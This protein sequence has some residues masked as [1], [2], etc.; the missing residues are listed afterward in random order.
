[1]DATSS[2]Q[3]Q[4]LQAGAPLNYVD[5][6]SPMNG[7]RLQASPTDTGTGSY[8]YVPGLSG[9]AGDIKGSFWNLVLSD[10]C[11]TDSQCAVPATCVSGAC[12]LGEGGIPLYIADVEKDT[13][14]NSSKYPSNDDIYLYTV[15]YRQPATGQWS[16]LCPLDIYGK[17]DAIAIPLD[18]SDWTSAASRAKFSFACT[19]SGVAAKC[20]RNWGYK[21]WKTVT[22][23]VWNGTGFV[24]TAVDLSGFYNTCLIAARADYCQDDHSYTKNGTLVDLFDTLD[25]FTSVNSTAG[26]AFAP[27][28]STVM[29]H[30]EYQI[31]V[32]SRVSSLFTP[33]ELSNM[34]VDTQT[35]VQSLRRSG[36]ES[37]RYA[38][39]D[40]G[41]SC[42]AAPYIERCDP[43]E[44]YACYR[45]I[46][47]SS[48]P[49]GA[50]LALNS[51]RHCSHDEVTDGEALDPLCN[52]CVNRVCQVDPTCCG[53]PGSG[54][55]PGSLV[56]D[57][58]CSTIRQQVCRSSATAGAPLWPLG[59]TAPPAGSHPT[60]FLNGAIGSFEGIVSQT[61]TQFAEGWACDPDF[62]GVSI[63]IQISVGGEL[64]AAGATLFTATADQPL[65]SGWKEAVAAECGGA[66]RQG[67]HFQLPAGSTGKDVFVYGIDLNVP[68]A[69]FSLLRGGMKT[70]PAG[71]PS[72]APMAAIWTGWVQP[73]APGNYSFYAIADST[74]QYRVWVNG[75]YVAGNWVDPDPNAPGAF[76]LPPPSP[77]PSLYL[78]PGVR[79]GVRVEYLRPA[80]LPSTS[81]FALDWS[82][83]GG[84]TT[85][86]IPS[87]AFYPMAQG[88]G[89]GLLGTYFAGQL[90][91]GTQQAT[92]TTGAVDYLWTSGKPPVPG[93]TVNNPFAATFEGQVVPPISG[94]YTFTTATDGTARIF[95]N[96]QLVTAGAIRPTGF[97]AETCSHDICSTGA[98]ISRTCP[99]GFF[100][101]GLICDFDPRCCSITWDATCQQEVARI[102][103]LDCN[104]TPPLSISL[105]AGVKY[106]IRVEYQHLSG[107]ATLQ[108]MWALPGALREVIPAERLFAAPVAGASAPGVGINAAYFSDAAFNAEYLDH[109]EAGPTFDAGMP[110][111]ATL[112]PSLICTSSVCGS[113]DPPGAPVLVSAQ[114]VGVNG[115]AVSVDVQGRGA[116]QGAA[117]EIWDGTGVDQPS[118]WVATTLIDSFTIAAGAGG[119]TFT[120]SLNL[121][122]GS[123]QLA[124]KQTVSAQ[125]SVFSPALVF[126]AADPAA[127]AAPTV[128]VPMGG[129]VSG[130]GKVQ[131]GGTAVP[132]ATVNVTAGG[133]TTLATDGS[134]LTTGGTTTTFATDG[135]GN[136]SGLLTLPSVG[137][138]NVCITQSVAGI[139]SAAGVAATVIVALPP[140]T[141]T[142]PIDG[143]TVSSPLG[144]VGSG[145]DPSLGNVIVGDGDGRFFA[146]RGT[147]SVNAGG[148]FSGGAVALD[149][150][151][152]QLK[153]FQRANGLDGD[154]VLRTVLVAPPVGELTI[155]SPIAGAIV[156]ASVHVQGTSGLVRNGLPGTVIVYQGATK[157]AEAPRADDGSFDI[158]VTLTG[159]G[160]VTL[161]V[162]QTASSLSGGGSAESARTA[163]I[164]IVLHPGAPTITLPVTGAVQPGLSVAVSGNAEPNAGVEIDVDGLSNATVSAT[165]GGTFSKTLTLT[166][167]T[168][169]ITAIQ[170]LS[171]STSSAS[172]SILVTLGDV[173]PPNVVAD[174]REVVV[175]A[176]DVIGTTVNFAS[177]V[178]ASDNGA[179][180]PASAITCLP[181]SGS[182]FPMG[183]TSVT[184][185]AL[186]ASGNRG[187]TAFLVTVTS[188]TGPTISGS[189]LVA[190][191]QGPSGAAVAYQITATGF[192]TNCAAPGSGLVQACTT[193]KP[194]YKG[195]GFTP[196]AVAID[197][198]DGPDGALYAGYSSFASFG[199]TNTGCKQALFKSLN[200]GASWQELALPE[201]SDGGTCS[202][203]QILVTPSSSGVPATIIYLSHF[204][205]VISRDGG[206][207]WTPAVDGK[208]MRGIA[209]DPTDSQHLYAWTDFSVSGAA[210]YETHDAWHTQNE[211]SDGLPASQILAV[212]LDPLNAGRAYLSI[213]PSASEV[214]RT[215]LYQRFGTGPWQRLSV[216]PYADTL[217]SAAPSIAIS[218]RL[219]LCQASFVGQSCAPCPAGQGQS[220]ASCQ[221][222]PTVYAGTVISRDGGGSW[223]DFPFLLEADAVVFDRQNPSTMYAGTSGNFFR[224][225]DAGQTWNPTGFNTAPVDTSIVQDV[226][227]S[228]TFYSATGN[229][230]FTTS[231]GGQDWTFVSAPGL[232]LG[233]GSVRDVAADPVD[234]H[235]AYLL[236]NTGIFKTQ[237]GGDNWTRIGAGVDPFAFQ[238]LSR[239]VV[240]RF[241]RNNVYAGAYGLWKSPDGGTNWT[242]LASPLSINVSAFALDPLRP[243][244]LVGT[245]E[246][247]P[248]SVEVF[249]LTAGTT[250][251]D[252]AAGNI[253]SEAFNP[254]NLQLVPDPARTVVFSYDAQFNSEDGNR[255]DVSLLSLVQGEQFPFSSST[256]TGLGLSNVIFNASD[257]TNRLFVSGSA[258]GHDPSVLYRARVTDLQWEALGGA[259]GPLD[260]TTLVVDPSS[261]GQVMYTT[262]DAANPDQSELWNTFW[263][264]HD[265][266]SSWQQD[267]S[268]PAHHVNNTWVSPVDGAVYATIMNG[269]MNTADRFHQI[270]FERSEDSGSLWKRTPTAGIPLGTP[271][272]EGDLRPVC[273]GGGIQAIGSGST[274]PIGDTTI[275]CTAKDAFGN[276]STK[277]ITITVADKT[278]PVIQVPSPAPTGVPGPDHT[279]SVSYTVTATDTVDSNP[280][281][282]CS[283]PSGSPF[284]SGVTTVRCTATDHAT[285]NPNTATA[286]FPVIVS[287]GTLT[288]PTIR[289]P[290]DLTAEATGPNG[291]SV[292]LAVTATTGGASPQ[293][294][295]PACN[296]HS[297][298]TFPI[299]AT[300]VTCSATN[301]GAT[302]AATF[303]VTVTDT[304]PPSVMTSG[305]KQVAAQGTWGADVNFTATAVDA[306]DGSVAVA[307]S[308]SSGA[309]F[310]L[311]TTQVSCHATDHT[312]NQA[313]AH[314]KITVADLNPPVLHLVNITVDAQDRTGARVNYVPPPFAT[315]VEDPNVPVDCLPASGS[316]FPLD[317]PTTVPCTATDSA[318]NETRGSFQ[319]LVTD[320]SPPTVTVPATITVEAA[321]PN[322]T[323]VPFAVSGSDIVSGVV[324]P[325]CSRVTGFGPVPVATGAVFPVGENQVN[326]VATDSAGNVGS[327]SFK[328]VVGDTT[329]PV[330][331]LPAPVTADADATAT[332]AVS[333]VATAVDVVAGTLPVACTPIP[334]SRFPLGTTTVSC[335]ARD[336]AGNVS[337][338]AFTVTVRNS[339]HTCTSAGDC[340]SGFCVDG[341]CCASACGGSN[342]T[343]C[344]ACS[345]AAG[346]STDGTCTPVSSGRI[347]RASAGVC[348]AAETCDGVS[349]A[350][351]SDG[352]APATT[353]CR[354]STGVCDV[355][356]TCTGSSGTCPAN[357]FAPATIV[358]RASTGICDLAETCS[359]SSA[360]CP[361]DGFAAAATVCRPS[362]GACDVAET[363]TGTSGACPANGF[364]PATTVCRASTGICDVAE[365]CSGTSA[366]CPADGFA[367]AATVCRASAGACDVAETC[368]GTSGT[369]PANGFAPTTTV[370]RASTGVCDVAETCS[371]TSASCPA[372]GFAPASHVCRASVGICDVAET[373][374]GSA[375]ACPAD[376]FATAG[377]VCQPALTSCQ[378]PGTCTGASAVCSAPTPIP[379][380][381]PPVV[382]VPANMTVEATGPAGATVTFQATAK[383]A[384]GHSLT[385]T[386][387]PVSG[388]PFAIGTKT[389][390]CKATDS[391]GLSGSASFTVTVADTKGPVFSNVPGTIT[392]FA[393][394]TSG[395]KVNYTKP[396]ATDA[397]DGARTVTCTPA[398]GAQFP[399]NKTT[400]TCSASDT[401]GHTSTATF[402]VW[403]TYQAP[404]DGSFFLAPIRANGSSIFKIGPPVP[405]RFK[406]TGASQNIT[407]LVAKLVVTKI[408]NTVQGTTVDTGDET[409][410]DTDFTFKFRQGMQFYAYRWKSRDQTQGTFQ[411]RADLG[412]G[413]VHQ[414][415]VSLKP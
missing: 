186:D 258:L 63:P 337:Q 93:L 369:C 50:F 353:I 177:H 193:W 144:V 156:N 402:T 239:V 275:T 68:G 98:A 252:F 350:C 285:P 249:E 147:V 167:G 391:S 388:T 280:I 60:V 379:N 150:G 42:A 145:A 4:G 122:K 206:Q 220:G 31:S 146:D 364:A 396:T 284:P 180:M 405:V 203:N 99:E 318:G 23:K 175:S 34:S 95:V 162:S 345:I 113:A 222:F 262:V 384:Q 201:T 120:R 11:T 188:A 365:T 157:V 43:K 302:V 119:G 185:Q 341:V 25:G 317:V 294:L 289:T 313:T 401:R 116:E 300:D 124:A 363:C 371:G 135:S 90:T 66:G 96:G 211:V 328:V 213:S 24:D 367:S 111:G 78:L 126:I 339:G 138:F 160:S 19:G 85:V 322:G 41:R 238:N 308:P 205:M 125:T 86:P 22:E 67:F 204:G 163:A 110:P 64:G 77:P 281:V 13:Q 56:W 378:A 26:L 51:P 82:R 179:A 57:S 202:V 368:T 392:A 196:T 269:N 74:D 253:P 121:T 33:L 44:P 173:T 306:V 208:D 240:D 164:T 29:L 404:T 237:D 299:G 361:A 408:S 303:R 246:D 344:Q 333:Y 182:L 257:G 307:C 207:S 46:N 9:A 343:D 106:D 265:G 216:P 355:A 377:T 270:G 10:P 286:S 373:C 259:G 263:E 84:A 283:P 172:Q 104:P 305:D 195:L 279:A 171:G 16:A 142:S 236:S 218:P 2:S 139:T 169:V 3:L 149:Y 21:P 411:L 348:D 170:T 223:L 61:G 397:V 72:S 323:A 381:G 190:E 295:T 320:L 62:P 366:S 69:P 136:W 40:P 133:T 75:M 360:T 30:E 389:V 233:A 215:K 380:C 137:S 358:C 183:S 70:V 272:V 15:Y 255:A 376:K 219:E 330:L 267:N 254:Y 128:T 278:P 304:Q 80:S 181:A 394:S 7:V 54:F 5:V 49:Y 413:V 400:V 383:D 28:S 129:F 390:T 407:N 242:D 52:E 87:T 227:Q 191:A 105:S 319:V 214:Q 187:S 117:V 349:T 12:S 92:Q 256:L 131:V 271:V 274:F 112:A 55:Y 342:L 53:D 76:T 268:P 334:G 382:T 266:G 374:T 414:V 335:L 130:N 314:F 352:F 73:S 247:F 71:T 356:E 178:S 38:D 127:P 65:V 115:N 309:A 282:N 118:G 101:S 298:D 292:T 153:I 393:T 290:G 331:V 260:F 332:A 224:S 36:M 351:P 340:S 244:T 6:P 229:G 199:D 161:S 398:S 325:V 315:D 248:S 165:A 27:Y 8:I 359:G 59:V 20:A 347:C 357:G 100:C 354:A 58:R 327:G 45:S 141:V 168:H 39:L 83:D 107:G 243:D 311:G 166:N 35:L 174:T 151:R 261:S 230:L 403:V 192:T 277:T 386:C 399:V 264:S 189:N 197:P 329:P 17:P 37:S 321:G 184:C 154:G 114:M 372:E 140:L 212:A 225:D 158:P 132:N 81:K 91:G 88:S 273:A 14:H 48:V 301:A 148:S 234:P 79:Y 176:S 97:N 375:A 32:A 103:G 409:V 293:R 231:D 324:A 209:A 316:W 297:G 221:T 291:A 47:M 134:C 245:F 228:Q 326:C 226:S 235:I 241:D 123:H 108:L 312:G 152:H 346:G 387:T 395:A 288:V 336:G 385:P 89:S 370:C 194:A 143:A 1:M 159:A 198:N 406:L 232:S 18:T 251:R 94:D 155:T 250:E 109:V 415:N 338:G 310:P 200:R 217:A 210:L 287:N 276:A 102:C 410:D 362:G 412:D 296:F